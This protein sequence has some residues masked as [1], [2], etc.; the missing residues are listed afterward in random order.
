MRGGRT[1]REGSVAEGPR[2]PATRHGACTSENAAKRT[3]PADLAGAA[4]A[5]GAHVAGPCELPAGEQVVHGV[6]DQRLPVVGAVDALETEAPVE[7]VLG[8]D[9]GAVLVAQ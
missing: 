9:A 8:G 7:R 5:G 2:P 6:G 4:P 1:S 3:C